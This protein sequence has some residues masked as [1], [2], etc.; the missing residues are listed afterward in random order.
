M[1]NADSH[2]QLDFHSRQLGIARFLQ[3]IKFNRTLVY[4]ER[5]DYCTQSLQSISFFRKNFHTI[6]KLFVS[7]EIASRLV[8]T[9]PA[10]GCARPT[11]VMSRQVFPS[12]HNRRTG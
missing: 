12:R 11:F 7:K 6:E 1:Q 8:A 5:S 10:Q 4:G 3:T 9:S 2:S